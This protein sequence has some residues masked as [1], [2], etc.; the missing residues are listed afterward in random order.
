VAIEHQ[1]L[2]YYRDADR[3]LA[4]RGHSLIEVAMRVVDEEH[5]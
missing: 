4:K 2:K 1:L 5:V 3:A